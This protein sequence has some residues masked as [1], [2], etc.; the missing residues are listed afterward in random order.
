MKDIMLDDNGNV[1]IRNNKIVVSD[2][3]LQMVQHLIVAYPGEF[4]LYPLLGGKVRN[5]LNGAIDP[6]WSGN[7][8][9]QLK[10]CNIAT[11]INVT[12]EN[13]EIEIKD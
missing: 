5:L 8:K 6:F 1:E 2:C 13:I 12:E 3:K 9:R 4:K 11:D 10:I 7:V